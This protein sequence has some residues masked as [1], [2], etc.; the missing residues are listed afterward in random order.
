MIKYIECIKFSASLVIESPI[1]ISIIITNK[2]NSYSFI[3]TFTHGKYVLHFMHI[4]TFSTAQL[5]N[6]YCY[7]YYYFISFRLISHIPSDCLS[8][9]I[10]FHTYPAML[11]YIHWFSC[12]VAMSLS[13]YQ[14]TNVH[15]SQYC[16]YCIRKFK[17]KIPKR[18]QQILIRSCSKVRAF[19][20]TNAIIW[21]ISTLI[22]IQKTK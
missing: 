8:D 3:D 15:K 7:Y 2:I 13:R 5:I 19:V 14:I 1:I 11:V 16:S 9:F 22:L 4:Q 6:H 21:S 10:H 17:K 20:S 18:L 12:I